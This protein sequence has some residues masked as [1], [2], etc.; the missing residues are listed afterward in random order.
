V[1]P[2][3]LSEAVPTVAFESVL[4]ALNDPVLASDASGLFLYSNAAAERLLGW[5]ARE[6]VG[7]P[8]TTI[9]PP[10][11]RDAHGAGF[12]R[13]LTTGESRII[14]R[15][16]R[17]PA[18]RR[19]GAEIDIE[20]TL[21]ELRPKPDQL[22]LIAVLR[23]L[24]ERTE[25]EQRIDT[26]QK[27]LAQYATVGVLAEAENA[28]EAMPRLLEA[29]AKALKWELGIFWAVD[30][31]TN[32][33][34]ASATWSSGSVAADRFVAGSRILTFGDG[35]G[36]PGRVLASGQVAWSRNIGSDTRYLRAR[37]TAQHGLRSAI[38]FPVYSPGRTWGVLEYL[39]GREEELDED[40][41]RTMTILG[42]QIGRFLERVER[43]D[44]LR[45]AWAEADAARMNLEHLFRDAPA[46]IAIVRGAEMRYTLSNTI[47]QQLAGGRE[48]VGKTV[49]EALPELEA[50]G[51]TAIVR[52]VYGTGEPYFAREFPVTVPAAADRPASRIFMNGVCQPLRGP[53]GVIEGAM[54]FAY[55]VT[56]LVSSRER[57]KDA[58]ERLRLAVESAK[59]GTWDYDPKSGTVRCDARHRRLFGLGPDAEVTAR[60]LMDAIHPDDRAQ[61][62]EAAQRS[63]DASTGGDYAAEF[64]VKGI[65][66]GVERWIA[67]R[68]RTFFDEQGK[69][70]RFVGT[71]IDVTGE[72]RALDEA[73]RAIG[74]RDQFLSIASHELRTPLT[75]LTLQLSSLSRLMRAGTLRDV[76]SEKLEG[77]LVRMEQ[78]TARLASLIDE[79]LDVSRISTGRLSIDHQPTDLVE[80]AREVL[81]RL[82]DEATAA[83]CGLELRAPASLIGAWDRNRMDQVLTNLVDN[84]IKYAGGQ[85]VEIEIERGAASARL[86]VRDRGP[87]VPEEEQ[88]R[89]FQQFERAAPA[90]MAG[91]GLGLWIASRIVMAHGGTI[92]VES[93]PGGGASFVVELPLAPPT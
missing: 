13:Y 11:L 75:S 30:R 51:V 71:G 63:F 91:L 12:H 15:P 4:D 79:L 70:T 21:S 18:L 58:E 72:R 28:A 68:G 20:L 5:T 65:E 84:A 7:K 35:E 67:V 38:L 81:E 8:L 49:R 22:V 61:V 9:M 16:V 44:Q 82:A 76:P 42:Y 45:G 66:D 52:H 14:G 43:E 29:A 78:Q 64:R 59:V 48:L 50:D 54:I 17:V 92:E 39:S 41:R 77:R 25:L 85:P 60:V 46:A 53:Q 69:P 27:I 32:R 19:D 6:L 1:R 34:E 89:I 88:E 83:R 10:R 3:R 80:I 57:V 55:D 74:V 37:L 36:L 73:K 23:D 40:L 87:G 93:R 33:L 26:Q 90:S 56:D 2:R 24:R 62:N 86:A 31:V 47:N